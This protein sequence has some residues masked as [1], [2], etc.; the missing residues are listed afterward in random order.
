MQYEKSF[1]FRGAGPPDGDDC[2]GGRYHPQTRAQL[3]GVAFKPIEDF[4]AAYGANFVALSL[5][6]L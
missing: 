3:K 5:I 2:Y 4:S 1:L 6:I